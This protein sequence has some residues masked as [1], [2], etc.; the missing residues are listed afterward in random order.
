M[1]T[2]PKGQK[3]PG[4]AIGAARLAFF[5]QELKAADMSEFSHKQG[6][7]WRQVF[8]GGAGEGREI[9][10]ELA[11]AQGAASSQDRKAMSPGL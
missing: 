6:M 11:L 4:D 9:G 1:P 8:K 2:G 7:P 5:F 3:R 10:A